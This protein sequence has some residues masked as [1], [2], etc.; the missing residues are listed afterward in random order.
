MGECIYGCVYVKAG[1]MWEGVE[2]IMWKYRAL[3]RFVCFVRLS[4]L[5]GVSAV[6]IVIGGYHMCGCA[7]MQ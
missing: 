6:D 1:G 5:C 7:Y 4:G 3:C 2:Y